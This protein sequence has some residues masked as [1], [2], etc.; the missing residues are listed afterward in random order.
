MGHFTTNAILHFKKVSLHAGPFLL[1]NDFRRCKVN[2]KIIH[3]HNNRHVHVY[4]V[5]PSTF[6]YK[7][8]LRMDYIIVKRS[9]PRQCNCQV[10]VL[11]V[12]VHQW[13]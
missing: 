6:S 9:V 8:Q 4:L 7:S 2:W 13:V 3:L 5:C 12:R 1:R 10:R 11:T